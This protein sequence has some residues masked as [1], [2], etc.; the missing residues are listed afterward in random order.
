VTIRK[1]EPWGAAAPRPADLVFAADDAELAQFVARDAAG[2]YGLRGGDLHRS[3]G[4]PQQRDTTQRIPVDALRV[5]FDDQEFLA[6]AHVVARNGWWRGP[7]LAVL[8]CQY[9][10]GW[11]VAPRAH[12]NDGHFDIVEVGAGMSL[13][14]RLQAR[15]RLPLGNHVPHPEIEVRTADS[16]T[17]N[18]D[19]PREVYVDGV[20]RG[21]AT[22][23]EIDIS[24]DHFSIYM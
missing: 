19:T 5:R 10:G 4:A 14:Q 22:R 23:L 12:P 7:L 3:L 1:G 6:I 20:P 21:R 11:D 15:R 9:I 2:A 24:P 13:R 17:W 16:A 18:F 8:N